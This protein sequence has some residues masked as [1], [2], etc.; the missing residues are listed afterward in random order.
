MGAN[1]N[2]SE[3]NETIKAHSLSPQLAL[4][5]PGLARGAGRP[6]SS[7]TSASTMIDCTQIK[8]KRKP[9]AESETRE[10]SELSVAQQDVKWSGIGQGASPCYES[11]DSA[12]NLHRTMLT[13]S[14]QK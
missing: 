13:S 12:R 9:L 6:A 2:W 11:T 7:P 10:I 4:S 3:A 14:R 8:M 5:G 1:N